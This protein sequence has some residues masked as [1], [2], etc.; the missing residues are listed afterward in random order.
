MECGR[1][2]AGDSLDLRIELT[3]DDEPVFYCAEC[4]QCEFDQE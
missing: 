1:K 3:I 4:W 2:L